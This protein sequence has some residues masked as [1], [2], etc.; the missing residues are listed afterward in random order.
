MKFTIIYTAQ[1]NGEQSAYG[2]FSSRE[3]AWRRLQRMERDLDPDRDEAGGGVGD[4]QVVQIR[5]LWTW[6]TDELG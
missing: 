5:P 2:N 1:D 6:E 3:A 4:L